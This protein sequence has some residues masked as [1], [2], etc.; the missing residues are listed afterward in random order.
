MDLHLGRVFERLHELGLY[1]DTL[2]VVTGDHGELL[3]EHG[4]H[5]HDAGLWEDEIRVPLIVKS[6]GD[7]IPDRSRQPIQLVDVMPLILDG[8]EIEIPAQ[9]QGSATPGTRPVFAELHSW[10]VR[11]A[12]V[13]AWIEGDFKLL[14]NVVGPSKLFNVV[15]NPGEDFDIGRYEPERLA[16]MTS[17]MDAFVEQLPAPRAAGAVQRL[18]DETRRALKSLGYLDE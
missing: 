7:R 6:A 13:R 5:G 4:I 1:D 2:I 17:A 16:R 12:R 3:G 18:D 9:V 10:K 15:K 11:R 8:L 14:R